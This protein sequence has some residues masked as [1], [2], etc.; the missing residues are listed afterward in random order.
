MLFSVPGTGAGAVAAVPAASTGF[1]AL[2]TDVDSATSTKMEFYTPDGELLYERFVPAAAGNDTLSFLGVSFNA[3]EVI[4]WVRITSG[5]AAPGPDDDG[6]RDVVMMDDFIYG[7]PVSTAVLDQPAKRLAFPARRV[8]HRGIAR[9]LPAGFASG[10]VTLDGYDITV[11]FLACVAQTQSA[12]G[13]STIRC[14]PPRGFLALGDHTL[15][16]EL[17]LTD[18]TRVRHAVLWRIVNAVP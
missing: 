8:R 18:N 17:T 11:P 12:L 2:F 13:G 5:N 16:I 6:V 14:Q 4:G 1:G 3:G 15:Q 10:K 7:E 9:D